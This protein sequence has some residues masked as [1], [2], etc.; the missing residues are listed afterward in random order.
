MLS[1]CEINCNWIVNRIN[2]LRIFCYK[3]EARKVYKNAFRV[4]RVE[5]K[6]KKSE[7]TYTA[8]ASANYVTRP[9]RNWSE[10]VERLENRTNRTVS[11]QADLGAKWQSDSFGNRLIVINSSPLFFL[12]LNSILSVICRLYRLRTGEH[13]S[14]YSRRVDQCA[15]SYHISVIKDLYWKCQQEAELL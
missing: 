12:N 3:F 1:K 6:R 2:A 4:L 13:E 8:S 11:K 14:I 5:R 7:Q 9:K 15:R 10:T